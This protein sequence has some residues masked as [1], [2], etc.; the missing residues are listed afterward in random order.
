MT[1]FNKDQFDFHGG[2]L[3]Y[4]SERKFVARFKRG[5]MAHFRAF[6]VKHFTVEEYFTLM[7]TKNPESSIGNTFAPL[8]ILERKGYVLK[9]IAD[10]LKAKGYPVTPAGFHQMIIDQIAARG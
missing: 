4:G 8:E 5:G 10:Q 6:L 9:H 2:Y 1:K 3:T 7:E